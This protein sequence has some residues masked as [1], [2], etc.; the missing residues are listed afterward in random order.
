MIK[1]V[2]QYRITLEA[3]DSLSE[4]QSKPKQITFYFENHDDIFKII[5]VAESKNIFKDKNHAI[6]FAL[7]LKLFTEVVLKNK[8]NPLF[9]DFKTAI[10]DFMKKLKQ[11]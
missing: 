6:E 9:E 2:N 11:S 1:K 4:S 10:G 8:E 7:G 3:I 5:E